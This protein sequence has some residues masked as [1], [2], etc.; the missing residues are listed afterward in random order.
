MIIQLKKLVD[1]SQMSKLKKWQIFG[2]AT[3]QIVRTQ[4]LKIMRVFLY[5]MI[6]IPIIITFIWSIRR[7]LVEESFKQTSFLW[8]QSFSSIDP[9]FVIPFMTVGC[10]YWNFQRFITP[11]NKHTLVSRLRGV[12]QV[13]V[14]LWLPI[15]CN[16]PSVIARSL[17][18]RTVLSERRQHL[19]VECSI[20]SR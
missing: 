9:Y 12:A 13:L 15:L 6:N 16:W 19:P 10:Y 8:V 3:Y 7:L 18:H 14:I 1:R 17:S 20:W 5:N 4:E 11:E 2:L